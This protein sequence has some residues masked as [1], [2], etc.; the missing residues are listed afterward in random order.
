MKTLLRKTTLALLL[1]TGGT[2]L[3]AAGPATVN[4]LCIN[5]IDGVQE[6]LMIHQ[7]LKI[8]V[9]A[10]GNIALVHPEI[11]VEYV[12]G[13]VDFFTLERNTDATDIYDG[14]H[15]SGIA[16][17][18]APG[19]QI[20]VTPEGITSAADIRVFDLKG[21]EVAVCRA[22]GGAATLPT[23]SLPKGVYIVTSGSTTLKIKL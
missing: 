4:I 6:R 22:E 10:E 23:A 18:E 13:E 9:G 7:D 21:V 14:D 5:R 1:G 16:A 3:Q 2:W 12:K 11:T 17:P 19:A 8:N 20:S 15:Q